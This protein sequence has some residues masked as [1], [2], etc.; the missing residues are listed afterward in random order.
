MSGTLLHPSHGRDPLLPQP[1]DG[2]GRGA[3]M[4]LAVHVLLVLA[5]A[6]AVNWRRQAPTPFSAE[7][8]AA[9]PEQAAPRPT[10]RQTAP[11]PTPAPPPS[12]APAPPPAPVRSAADI[13]L[14]RQRK[15][16]EERAARE[17]REQAE[18]QARAEARERER[19]AQ[20][21]KRREAEEALL[22]QQRDLQ[23]K[24][25]EEAARKAEE[26]RQAAALE[27][28]RQENLKRMLGQAGATGTPSSR[29]SGQRDA[30]PSAAYAGRIVAAIRPN[31]VLTDA[32]PPSLRAVVEVSASPT[33][34]VLARRLV[35]SSGNKTW[36]DAVLRAIDRT[37]QL[38]ADTN[39][40]VP[41]RLEIVFTPE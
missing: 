29:G 36:D 6:A 4:A 16:D 19:Q 33:G 10:A 15:L 41:P 5:L 35:E 23:K 24:R 28:Q 17:A 40:R 39:G 13:A 26:A 31:I 9:L 2:L 14:E 25:Q 37:R 11:A 12:A 34:S 21:Q 1:A 8:W 30:A 22:Q 20:A 18:Q 32:L 27:K 38:P 3:L 7:I